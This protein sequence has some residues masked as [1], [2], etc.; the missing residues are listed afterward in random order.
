M[1][2]HYPVAGV[3]TTAGCEKGLTRNYDSKGHTWWC[4]AHAVHNGEVVHICSFPNEQGIAAIW[5]D[6]V[7]VELYYSRG[8]PQEHMPFDHL[9][10]WDEVLPDLDRLAPIVTEED[11]R[12]AAEQ[13]R[14][15]L[16]SMEATYADLSSD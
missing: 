10:K 8:G 6:D 9:L 3:A 7:R 4:T 2:R 13:A 11:V 14:M 1:H 15:L 5:L 12:N 16:I